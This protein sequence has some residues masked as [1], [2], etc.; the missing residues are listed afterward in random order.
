MKRLCALFLIVVQ[1][2]WAAADSSPPP[3]L[4]LL[5]AT[6]GRES[7]LRMLESLQPQLQEQDF[8]T[9]VFDAIDEN[10]VY[11][12]AEEV[13][14][15]FS[16][17]SSIIME[18]KNLGWWGHAIRNKYSQLP[19][20]FILHADD[21][22][23]YT[24]DAMATIRQICTDRETLYVFKMQY[25]DGRTL[26]IDPVIKHCQIG[27]P[28]GVIPSSY[29]AKTRWAEAFAGD[30]TFYAALGARVPNVEFVDHVIY[31]VRPYLMA[32]T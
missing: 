16:C 10:S 15:E 14:K 11:V 17:S 30:F 9:V 5:I 7:L 23:I 18:P 26:W 2:V 25:S 31:L 28:M 27:T 3:S 6:I 29:N 13:L 20:D 1:T 21:D 24:E 22:D 19:G 12:R 8:L 4:H 32:S